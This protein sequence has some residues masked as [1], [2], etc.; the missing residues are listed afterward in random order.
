MHRSKLRFSFLYFLIVFLIVSITIS[1][2]WGLW[3]GPKLVVENI[4]NSALLNEKERLELENA[5]RNSLARAFGTVSQSVGGIVLIIGI[6]FTWRNAIATEDKQVTERF[7]KAIE[8]LS[9][10]ATICIG[11]IYALERIANDSERD[12]WIVMEVLSS[13]VRNRSS[14]E[15]NRGNQKVISAEVQAALDVIKRRDVSKDPVKAT[16][17]LS[18]TYLKGANF[19]GQKYNPCYLQEILT[20]AHA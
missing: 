14:L 8:Q 4:D 15:N 1:A 2:V 3:E 16:V 20:Q 10:D 7:T 13:F 9:G 12:H 19:R 11:G 17:D 5:T 18:S 6:Y